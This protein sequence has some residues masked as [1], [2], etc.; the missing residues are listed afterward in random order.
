MPATNENNSPSFRARIETALERSKLLNS[1]TRQIKVRGLSV[2]HRGYQWLT[3]VMMYSMI[4]VQFMRLKNSQLVDAFTRT[5]E[6]VVIS[7]VRSGDQWLTEMTTNSFLYRW[8]TQEPESD[9]IVI[10]LRETWTVGRVITLLEYMIEWIYPLWRRS[11]S[12]R[13]ASVV[14]ETSERLANTR[15]GRLLIRVFE[16][17]EPPREHTESKEANMPSNEISTTNEGDE[18]DNNE[19]IP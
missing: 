14:I 6:S 12:A 7:A 5:S 8:F 19:R 3:N 18:S 4:Y 10:D 16:P 17:P 11:Q 15:Y 2:V 13:V 9:V 1:D